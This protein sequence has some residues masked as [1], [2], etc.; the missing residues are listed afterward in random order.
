[1]ES[2]RRSKGGLV[3]IAIASLAALYGMGAD[4]AGWA[5]ASYADDG[6]LVIYAAA[7]ADGNDSGISWEDACTFLQDALAR[8]SS[9]H[10]PCEIRVAQGVYVPDSNST[11]PQGSADITAV[12]QLVPG[13]SLIGGYA[14]PGEDSP[15][16]RDPKKYVTVLSGDLAQND[17][18]PFENRDDNSSTVV[19]GA[20][21]ATIDG[22]VIRGG[23]YQPG[24]WRLAVGGMASEYGCT[25]ANCAF[26]DNTGYSGGGLLI[27][28]C[29]AEVRNCRFTRNRAVLRGGGICCYAANIA[30]AD[31]TIEDN[32][33]TR[34]QDLVDGGDGGGVYCDA[35]S[36][37]HMTD[38]TIEGNSAGAGRDTFDWECHDGGNGGDG[39]GVYCSAAVIEGCLI[40]GNTAGNGGRSSEGGADDGGDGGH[41]A[42]IYAL[43]T[44]SLT[45]S[46]CRI[47][48]NVAGSGGDVDWHALCGGSG[49]NGGSGG[50]VSC[51]EPSGPV[52][53][54]VCTIANNQT[55]RGGCGQG[56]SGGN[57][58]EA[59]NG[60]GILCP[61]VEMLNCEIISNSTGY[62][63]WGGGNSP[64]RGG[65]AGSGAGVYSSEAT[66]RNC[67]VAGNTTGRGGLGG[68]EHGGD[69]GDGG[70]GA[71]IFAPSSE[72]VNC[73][74]AGNVA[75]LGGEAVV[76]WDYEKD[77]SPGAGAG[78]Y[79]DDQ[80][81]IIDSIL[82]DNSP[83][84]LA[85][86]DCNNVSYCCLAGQQ[87]AGATGNIST[88]P[89]L[90]DATG[91]DYHLKSAS[92]RWDAA[93]RRWVADDVNSP[94]IDAG[95]PNSDAFAAELLSHGKRINMGAYGGTSQ[96]S[97][98]DSNYGRP[99]DF[100]SSDLVDFGDYALLASQWGRWYGYAMPHGE[101][102]VDANLADWSDAAW[103]SLDKLYYL[104][105]NDVS[106]AQ[107]AIC[108]NGRTDKVYA[109][110]VVYDGNHVFTDSYESW[111]ASDRIELF[112][113]GDISDGGARYGEGTQALHATAQQ[114]MVGPNTTGGYWAAWGNGQTIETDADIECAV[115]VDG[116]CLIYE[117][118]VKMF[119]YYG[120]AIGQDI[121]ATE[122]TANRIVGFD[123]A[124]DTRWGPP[125]DNFG[126]LSENLMT[127][128]HRDSTNFA[129]YVLVDKLGRSSSIPLKCDCDRNTVVNAA[130]LALLVQQWLG[131]M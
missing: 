84:G 3:I 49:G 26:E 29:A 42:G 126:M 117:V 31:C 62:G 70:N 37:L 5:A 114:Y 94:C 30:I 127:G 67:V 71:G 91:A 65:H 131:E 48:G 59:G 78:V 7:D 89:L 69:G 105:P 4:Q 77:G 108:W 64:S 55:G 39:G 36:I 58:G 119:D 38:C 111:D 20:Q 96:A 44:G 106:Q 95:D 16:A 15:D 110:I 88:D 47:L 50:G 93:N 32:A 109:A 57:G 73:T 92:G 113:D 121:V 128:K 14:G 23:N 74:I 21:G 45:I 54:R 115:H 41:G 63:G 53:V 122:L 28:D 72:I 22:F 25:I 81:V 123:I 52:L 83:H 118:G 40:S 75:G 46:D 6:T 27:R 12:F 124:V 19:L 112:S 68:W 60:G 86:H 76:M 8:A 107:V 97:I 125:S 56:Y 90:A 43:R 116:D 51:V 104:D 13:I 1:M 80:T 100:D 10:G 99:G 130:D 102:T 9:H 82:W 33:A 34:A 103:I 101:V 2:R 98:S 66:I 87:C 79:G 120:A 85:G 129:R 35:D 17:E 61:S 24:P 11:T 18:H